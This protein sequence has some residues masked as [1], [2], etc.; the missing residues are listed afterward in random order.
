MLGYTD[1]QQVQI[2]IFLLKAHGIKRVVA[3]P[4]TTNMTFV[5][6]IQNDPFFTVYS[7]VDE[8]SA[9]YMACGLSAETGAP[10]VITCTGATASRNYASGLTEAFYRKLPI[11]AV[12]ATQAQSRVGHNIAQVIDRSQIQKDI[13]KISIDLPIV[14]DLQDVT[15][16]E[17]AINNAILELA[18]RG[19]G[20][21][22]INLPTKYSRNFHTKTLPDYRVIKRIT[23]QDKFPPLE[24]KVGVFIGAHKIW[25]PE[26]TA[27]LEKFCATYGAAVF[28]DH[29]SGY[30]GEHRLLYTLA[31]A[32]E[33]FDH[34]K[35]VPET[36]IHVGEITGDYE[37]P[38]IF[39]RN[40]WRVSPD[41]ELRDTFGRL[42]YIF[43]MSEQ[44]FFERYSSGTPS[45][46]PLSY[47]ETCREV[48]E[49]LRKKLPELPF[50]NLWAASQLAPMTPSGSALHLGILN[51]LRAWNFF[52]LSP[53]ID[54]VSNVGGFGIDGCVSSLVGASLADPDKL[55]F[56]V[57]GDLAFFYD[58]NVL[59]NRHLGA[60]VRLMVVNNGK[61]VEFAQYGHAGSAIGR[62]TED[63]VAAAGHFGAKSETLI[64]S[65][66]E[67]LGFEY[68]TASSKENFMAQADRFL[69]PSLSERP[70]LFEIF[71]DG[72]EESAALEA[73][74]NLEQTGRSR[75]KKIAKE[76]LGPEGMQVARRV[77]K[78]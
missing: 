10:V 9:A 26:E 35:I 52:E 78:K 53:D 66:A 11:L 40:V 59:G 5:V 57:I 65:Y 69:T 76:L 44:A 67:S 73:I 49:S 34:S 6:S 3:S 43:E 33:N 32:Q 19:G 17:L 4:G 61:G 50:S 7:C 42:R 2:L 54:V 28:C 21:V 58:M 15:A 39:K 68:L 1:E 27:S 64:K 13:A 60:N 31:A 38:K 72:D 14:K 22:H 77:L 47:A 20:P 29:T 51:S 12:T 24:G 70:M 46:A 74:R 45:L 16:C 30:K 18:R 41:G 37:T 71:T 25:T 23:V 56:G 36:L 63:Y 75:A 8:R 55:Y 62:A 48:I